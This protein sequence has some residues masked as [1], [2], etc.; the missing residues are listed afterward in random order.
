MGGE[1]T[2]GF[3]CERGAGRVALVLVLGR[4]D[5]RSEASLGLIRV[6]Y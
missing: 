5:H 6:F 4:A 1:F 3:R 2:T